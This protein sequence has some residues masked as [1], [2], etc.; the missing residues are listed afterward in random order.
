MSDLAERGSKECDISSC[1]FLIWAFYLV[2]SWH[3][4]FL[5][6]PHKASSLTWSLH[7]KHYQDADV[8]PSYNIIR[9]GSSG[10]RSRFHCIIQ[11]I[12][13]HSYGAYFCSWAGNTW[14]LIIKLGCVIYEY[15]PESHQWVDLNI[16]FNYISQKQFMAYSLIWAIS[17]SR[18]KKQEGGLKFSWRQFLCT[19]WLIS[20]SQALRLASRSSYQCWILLMWKWGF[21]KQL[22]WL[23]DIYRYLGS[24]HGVCTF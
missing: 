24:A 18:N 9:D 7:D 10:T 4:H 13:G 16:Y 14:G 20:L 8:I 3:L 2:A 17:V 15:Y 23:I 5:L 21:Q 19:N 11:T 6:P 1:I 12:Q 22:N